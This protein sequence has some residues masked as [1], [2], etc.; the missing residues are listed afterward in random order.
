MVHGRHRDSMDSLFTG[1]VR[2]GKVCTLKL[3]LTVFDDSRWT[4]EELKILPGY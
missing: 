4:K 2:N 3:E 1:V